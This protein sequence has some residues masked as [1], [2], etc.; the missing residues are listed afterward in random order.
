MNSRSPMQGGNSAPADAAQQRHVYTKLCTSQYKAASKQSPAMQCTTTCKLRSC[1][2]YCVQPREI[3]RDVLRDVLSHAV[4]VRWP[5]RKA[6]HDDE[7]SPLV[8]DT[9]NQTTCASKVLSRRCSANAMHHQAFELC[10]ISKLPTKSQHTCCQAFK[11]C[12]QV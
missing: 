7:A 3:T 8:T 11:L 4:F 2:L 12:K 1:K 9:A 10:Q 5:E 6:S